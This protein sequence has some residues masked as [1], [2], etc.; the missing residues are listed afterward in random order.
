MAPVLR[1]SEI[2]GQ[3]TGIKCPKTESHRKKPKHAEQG[4]T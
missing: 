4:V 1:V 2:I 3:R